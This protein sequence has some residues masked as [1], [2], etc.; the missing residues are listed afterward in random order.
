MAQ[1]RDKGD[2]LPAFFMNSVPKSGTHLLKQLLLGMP[3]VTHRPSNEL[4]EGYPA[5]YKQ[6]Y[7][8]LKGLQ[9]NEFAAGHIYYSAGWESMLNQLG[10]KRL[11]IYRDP[12][13]IIVSY[14]NFILEK[15]PYHPLNDYL[16]KEAFTQKE[17]YLA[18]IH[19]V[20][21]E[22]LIY[23]N[24]GVW[25]NQFKGWIYD[26]NTLSLRFEDLVVS[27]SSRRK[28]LSR[29]VNY[30]WGGMRLPIPINQMIE[31]M[32]KNADPS[33]SLTFRSG[34]IG[35]W[36]QEF[37]PGVKAAFKQVAGDLLVELG[38]ENN[39]HW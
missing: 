29:L 21:R 15:Y 18:F 7:E 22:D 36:K 39:K 12:R 32:E 30:L 17:R 20:R 2:A 34:K 16:K 14:T 26:A 8:K 35:S 27:R 33:K 4:Y 3:S 10:M 23:P 31:M 38:Y 25:F 9:L 19:G 13:D 37:D 28:Q 6:H 24:I 1:E 5:Q 11:F